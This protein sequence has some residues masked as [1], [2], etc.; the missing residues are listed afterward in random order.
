MELTP[1]QVQ[2]LLST[3]PNC[4]S[5]IRI[6]C[7]YCPRKQPNP[8]FTSE[9]AKNLKEYCPHLETLIIENAFLATY[10]TLTDIAVD[11]LPQKICVLSLRGSI[12]RTRYFFSNVNICL[13]MKVLDFSSC[14]CIRD[15]HLACFSKMRSLEEL[16]LAGCQIYHP[17]IKMLLDTP[18]NN[19][20]LRLKVL[21]LESTEIND[22][23]I[24]LLQERLH[25]LEKL[26][27]RR[28]KLTDEC[29]TYLDRYS[30]QRLET[31]CLQNT[32]ITYAGV[33][34]LLRLQS[35]R[36][37]T[38]S[39]SDIYKNGVLELHPAWHKMLRFKSDKADDPLFCDHFMKRSAYGY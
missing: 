28:T 20:T 36:Y 15:N 16:Y 38:L 4:V 6:C 31:L 2:K 23:T 11:N 17:G 3:L 18:Q 19:T 39:V 25:T 21:D 22:D 34:S 7:L 30:F 37:I 24:L 5:Y 8:I 33:K 10:K 1:Y 14:I 27:L 26:Y 9:N 13:N 32:A 29:F 35:L 12:F